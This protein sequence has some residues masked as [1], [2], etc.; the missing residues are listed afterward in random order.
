MALDPAS[1]M[2]T[3]RACVFHVQGI[4]PLRPLRLFIALCRLTSRDLP[5]R[6]RRPPTQRAPRPTR[7]WTTPR[8]PRRARRRRRP[9]PSRARAGWPTRR[10]RT[11]PA[12]P[13]RRRR[14]WAPRPRPGRAPRRRRALGARAL[15]VRG[16]AVCYS[17]SLATEAAPCACGSAWLRCA[18]RPLGH[19]REQPRAGRSQHAWAGRACLQAAG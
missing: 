16:G 3:S 8:A 15:P 6:R 2:F 11:S 4:S 1:S 12:R 7:P 14:A 10:S 19:S 17:D 18:L 13:S 5:R 9:P